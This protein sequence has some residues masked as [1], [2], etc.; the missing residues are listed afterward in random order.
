[1]VPPRSN[2]QDVQYRA[3]AGL[4]ASRAPALAPKFLGNAYMGREPADGAIQRRNE[5]RARGSALVS[6]LVAGEGFEP[7]T[8]G[9]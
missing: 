7:P 4:V 3:N 5:G 9:L 2:H 1:V 8:F 6:V